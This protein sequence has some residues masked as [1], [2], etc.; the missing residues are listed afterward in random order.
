MVM[1]VDEFGGT[2]GLVTINDLIAQIIGDTHEPENS[3]TPQVVPIDDFTFLVQAQIDLEELNEF[4]NLE[5]PV[6]DE[7]QTLGGFILYHFQKIPAIGE[8]LYHENL[9]FTVVSADGPRLDQI[10]LHLGKGAFGRED[11]TERAAPSWGPMEREE[12]EKSADGIETNLDTSPP[13]GSAD[14]RLE[15]L[16]EPPLT[17]SDLGLN[18]EGS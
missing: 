7:Y 13:R 16:A 1:V 6:I 8:T 2:A 4:L 11:Q 17:E 15:P 3:V 5:L 12:E 9:E 14:L 18:E 10:R